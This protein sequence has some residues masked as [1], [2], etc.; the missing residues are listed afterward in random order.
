MITL[1]LLIAIIEYVGT[2]FVLAAVQIADGFGVVCSKHNFV[3][4]NSVK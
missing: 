3:L 1:I 4:L 2:L